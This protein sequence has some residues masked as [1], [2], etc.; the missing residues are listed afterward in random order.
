MS[1]DL[2]QCMEQDGGKCISVSAKGG[3]RLDARI[4]CDNLIGAYPLAVSVMEGEHEEVY[5][6]RNDGCLHIGF[7]YSG[8]FLE[9]IAKTH[10]VWLYML[11]HEDEP[12]FSYTSIGLPY[13]GSYK[14]LSSTRITLKEGEFIEESNES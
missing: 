14:V 5:R 3:I 12:A 1:F 7:R 6:C 9:N 4:I 10:D 11:Q 2:K 8:V 13:N